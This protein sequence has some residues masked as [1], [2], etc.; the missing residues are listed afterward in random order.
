METL[1]VFKNTMMYYILTETEKFLNTNYG[2]S[3]F[4][5]SSPFWM[6]DES[7]YFCFLSVLENEYGYILK[8]RGILTRSKTFYINNVVKE[9]M[10]LLIEYVPDDKVEATI[11]DRCVV[12]LFNKG[13]VQ[14]KCGHTSLCQ[15]CFQVMVVRRIGKCPICRSDI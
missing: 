4:E 12:C 7:S 2:L 5:N 14:L 6:A 1:K 8:S 3:K 10:E 9:V 15:K 13:T 11:D